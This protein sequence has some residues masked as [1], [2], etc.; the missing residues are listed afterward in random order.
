MKRGPY[1]PPSPLLPSSAEQGLELPEPVRIVELE[2]ADAIDPAQAQRVDV[3]YPTL[4]VPFRFDGIPT[5]VDRL[6]VW[7]TPREPFT[8]GPTGA[9]ALP[10]IPAVRG[11]MLLSPGT[12]YVLP[13]CEAGNSGPPVVLNPVRVP[14]KW[15]AFDARIPGVLERFYAERSAAPVRLETLNDVAA[16]ATAQRRV[17]VHQLIDADYLFL[18]G[19]DNVSQLLTFGSPGNLAPG[20][21]GITLVGRGA[22]L[23]WWG[24]KLALES[25]W[26]LQ[27]TTQGVVRV[28]IGRFGG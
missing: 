21:R 28:T 23:E 26:L 25:V 14:W 12:W 9:G 11:R 19:R 27:I 17:A 22:V 10:G 1:G 8:A 2:T 20:A 24:H 15:L 13:Y 7:Y 5:N 16:S 3:Q 6:L 18:Q 4:L